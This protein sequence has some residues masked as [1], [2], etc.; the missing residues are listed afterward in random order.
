M[1]LREVGAGDAALAITPDAVVLQARSEGVAAGRVSSRIFAIT[2]AATCVVGLMCDVT[3]VAVDDCP[4]DWGAV[5]QQI[6]WR[7]GDSVKRAFVRL[8]VD[9]LVEFHSLGNDVVFVY[10]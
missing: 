3:L 8:I 1:R 7:A 6:A 9:L 4:D 5:G 2:G 10:G